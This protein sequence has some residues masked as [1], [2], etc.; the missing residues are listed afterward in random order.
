LLNSC[1]VISPLAT[2]AASLALA[3]L[4]EAA[5]SVAS[6]FLSCS[7][8]VLGLKLSLYCG[9]PKIVSVT[10]GFSFLSCLL[11][12]LFSKCLAVFSALAEFIILSALACIVD[13]NCWKA[14]WSDKYTSPL[15]PSA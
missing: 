7:F 11:F 13:C 15:P 8:A 5:V 9:S 4:S 14:G 2:L 12:I 1:W 3:F 6:S 10:P